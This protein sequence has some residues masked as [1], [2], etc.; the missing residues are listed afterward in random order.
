MTFR[1]YI[2]GAEVQEPDGF[3]D[4]QQELIRDEKERFIRFNF[5]LDLTFIGDGYQLIE[6]QYQENYNSELEYKVVRLE[7]STEFVEVLSTI[8]ISNCEFN[9]TAKPKPSVNVQIDDNVFQAK[10][11]GNK[12]RPNVITATKTLNGVELTPV[13]AKDVMF[14][15]SD[16]GSDIATRKVYD[17][18]DCL[19]HTIKFIS[20][21]KIQLVSDW[22]TDLPDDEKLAITTGAQIRT[23]SALRPLEP[24]TIDFETLFEELYKKYNLYFIVED[25]LTDTPKLRLEQE[26]YLYGNSVGLEVFENDDLT[27]SLDFDK[28]YNR[29]AIGSDS[30]KYFGNEF[31]MYYTQLLTFAKETYN[32]DG[33]IGVDNELDLVSEYIIGSNE[34]HRIATDQTESFDEDIIMIQY[35][36]STNAA[37]KGDWFPGSSPSFRYYNEELNNAK[38]IQRFDYLGDVALS[39]GNLNASFMASQT[40]AYAG[41]GSITAPSGSLFDTFPV[42]YAFQ[43]DSTPPNYNNGDFDLANDKYVCANDGVFR[44]EFEFTFKPTAIIWISSNPLAYF[45]S[46][47]VR[48]RKNGTDS[49][50]PNLI[51]VRKYDSSGDLYGIYY[52]DQYEPLPTLQVNESYNFKISYSM[53]L[54]VGDYVEAYANIL[55]DTPENIGFNYSVYGG[56]FSVPATPLDG[57]VYVPGD[58]ERYYIGVY[59]TPEHYIELT[60][61]QALSATP[62]NQ[63]TIDTGNND[64][65]KTY[66]SKIS[67]NIVDGKSSIETIFNRDQEFK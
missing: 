40:T 48:F 14:F 49:L 55:I 58:P 47:F 23:P 8:K 10:I 7:V 35:D 16:T 38:V 50:A 65:R 26:S 37:V 33:V 27:R 34:I 19:E 54:E 66:I 28:L 24:L 5:P 64:K 17:V 63:I 29:I 30:V 15:N 13:T 32:I 61:W 36:S 60:D 57:G 67:R 45:I 11:F 39:I 41:S 18:F 46:P 25:I 9:L 44:F 21:G 6:N 52:I 2:N 31:P 59:A 3:S 51:T 20:D 43:D 1:H 53:E 22:Y 4:F 62:I 56:I 42:P 12:S